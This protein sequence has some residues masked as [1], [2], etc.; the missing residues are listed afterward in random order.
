MDAN[1]KIKEMEEKLK[2]MEVESMEVYAK[3][4]VKG[5]WA[6]E[7]IAQVFYRLHKEAWDIKK[8]LFKYRSYRLRPHKKTYH[9]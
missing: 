9:T 3:G 7:E 8:E 1:D 2:S 5:T 6:N 4:F